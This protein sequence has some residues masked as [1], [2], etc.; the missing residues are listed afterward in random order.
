MVPEHVKRGWTDVN[1]SFQRHKEYIKM[2]KERREALG[3]SVILQIFEPVDQVVAENALWQIQLTFTIGK[4]KNQSD[5][6]ENLCL[7]FCFLTWSHLLEDAEDDLEDVITATTESVQYDH[8]NH[9]VTVTT[10]SDLD[11]TGAHMLGPSANQVSSSC[12]VHVTEHLLVLVLFRFRCDV[13][14][15]LLENTD[16]SAMSM[17]VCD[18]LHNQIS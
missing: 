11:L 3:E 18:C 7:L 14:Q 13:G 10:I 5:Y 9:T 1:V 17:Y 2:L 6:N 4:Y 16:F 8:P 15:F 12:S